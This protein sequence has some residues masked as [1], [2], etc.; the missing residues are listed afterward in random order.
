MKKNLIILLI[1]AIVIFIIIS[2]NYY[3][4]KANIEK[5]AEY[6]KEYE[7][8]LSSEIYGADIATL[9]NKAVNQNEKNGIE[10]DS[11]NYFIE[12]NE[13]SIKIDIHILENDTIYNMERIN[14]KPIE[15][16]VKNFNTIKFKCVKKEYHESTQKIKYILFEQIIEE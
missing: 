8:Y 6:N 11:Q 4:Y 14:K 3:E 2:Y 9:I 13:N 1:F 15:D 5:T 7:Q 10:R 16:F 12:N